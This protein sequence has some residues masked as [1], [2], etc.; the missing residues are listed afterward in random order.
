MLSFIRPKKAPDWL[1][2]TH[3]RHAPRP[4]D[5]ARSQRQSLHQPRTQTK[6]G[7]FTEEKIHLSR[8]DTGTSPQNPQKN[9]INDEPIQTSVQYKN[10]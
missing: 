6:I 10:T 3:F 7:P 4:A 1:V 9:M 5:N 2:L 8:K